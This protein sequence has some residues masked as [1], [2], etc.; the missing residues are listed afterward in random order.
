MVNLKFIATGTGRSGSV[1]MA[2]L[3]TSL[4]VPCGHEA[5]FNYSKLNQIMN[6][7]NNPKLRKNSIVSSKDVKTNKHL[8]RW[9]KT[10]P[11]AESSYMAAPYLHLPELKDIP[12]IHVVRDPFKV[13]SSF[14]GD[15]NY[16]NLEFVPCEWQRRIYEFL[17]ELLEINNQIERACLYYVLWN[18]MI[19]KQKDCRPYFFSKLEELPNEEFYKFTNLAPTIELF[20]QKDINH[21]GK[22][23][24][25]ILL[26]DIPEGDIKEKFIGII[27]RYRYPLNKKLYD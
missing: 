12:V 11:I 2:R 25:D 4:G 15:L 27:K 26:Q 13:I 7:L 20:S 23:K 10:L 1:Y 3:L 9:L 17:P 24:R 21:F 8:G 14:I 18:E 6:K 22:R 16:F 19:E 5:I